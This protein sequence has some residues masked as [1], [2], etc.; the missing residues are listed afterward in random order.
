M[1][2]NRSSR[3]TLI[4]AAKADMAAALGVGALLRQSPE[5]AMALVQA[6]LADGLYG[7]LDWIARMSVPFTAR[8]EFLEAW[9]ALRGVTRNAATAATGTWTGT[10]SPVGAVLPAGTSFARADGVR[11]VSTAGG[12]VNGLGAVSVPLQAVEPGA[13]GNCDVGTLISLGSAVSGINATGAWSAS[14]TPGAEQELDDDL[15]TRTM[16]AFAN[17]PQGGAGADYVGWATDVS[18]VTRAWVAPNGAG[19]GTVVVYVMLDDVRAGGGGFP[20]G[21]DGVATLESRAVAATGDQLAVADA[22]F[23]LRPVTALVYVAAPT[24]T[25]VNP[26]VADLNDP[27][28]EAAVTTA[29]ADMLR[30]KAGVGG[31]IFPSTSSATIYPSDFDAAIAAVPGVTRFTLVSPSAPITAAAGHIHTLGTPTYT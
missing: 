7:Y 29:M 21:T 16:A 23:P 30:Q 27:S 14:L 15:F 22:I 31:A 18:G 28:L 1:P 9:A 11:Y 10:G 13:A 2:F 19:A 4:A 24:A 26:Q 5:A 8:G 3:S 20:T 6:A 17:P 25:A 12:V